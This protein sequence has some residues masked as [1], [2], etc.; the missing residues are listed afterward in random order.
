MIALIDVLNKIDEIERDGVA[1]PF[2]IEFVTFNRR[3]KEGGQLIHIAKAV[4]AYNADKD[5]PVS[6]KSSSIEQST[7]RNPQ[8]TK[9]MTRNIQD[10]STGAIKKI[11]IRLITSFNGETV[12][13]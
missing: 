12:F 4:K 5:L 10:V 1:L 2:S 13:Y 9:N 6:S 7:S 8:H 3:T 11:N